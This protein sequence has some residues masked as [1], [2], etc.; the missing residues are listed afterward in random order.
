[1]HMHIS[2]AI[3][4]LQQALTTVSLT[5]QLDAEVL[6]AHVLQKDRSWLHAYGNEELQRSS[7]HAFEEL[8]KRRAA[9]EPIAYLVGY[10]EFY[11]R[12]FIVSPSVLVPRPES[13]S[14]LALIKD[15]VKTPAP[16]G[17]HHVLDMG[18][19]SGCLAIT[20][21]LEHPKLYVSA[22]DISSTALAIAAH[23]ALTHGCA[24]TFK[25]QSLLAGDKEGYDL[26]VANL[27]YVPI[28]MQ[29]ASIAHE[30]TEALY[31]GADGLDHYKKLFVQLAHKHIRYVM[32]ESLLEQHEEVKKLASDAHYVLQKTEG[33]VQ[34]FV[35]NTD[36]HELLE[37]R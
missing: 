34:L 15:L 36:I 9:G 21:K 24:I 6:L 5:P 27:P 14:F 28:G 33:L 25:K 8:I 35:K 29:H 17:I 2:A 23:N 12:N 11:G 10:K 13:E 22:T 7:L 31:S 20:V 16:E 32:T 3:L 30:P 1:M 37:K 4:H 18:T 26:I 19:G